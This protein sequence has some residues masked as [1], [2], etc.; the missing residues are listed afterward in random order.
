MGLRKGRSLVENVTKIG[1]RMTHKIERETQRT[2]TEGE[3]TSTRVT[4]SHIN[5]AR[6]ERATQMIQKLITN[7]EETDAEEIGAV[8]QMTTAYLPTENT[9]GTGTTEKRSIN[10]KQGT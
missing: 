1:E 7:K 5:T 4:K 10:A 3:R 2:S 9:V 6:E 8:S